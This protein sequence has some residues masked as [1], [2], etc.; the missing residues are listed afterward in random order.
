[1]LVVGHRGASA[2]ERENSVAAFERA[3]AQG[4]DGAELDVRRTAD[5]TLAVHHDETLADGRRLLELGR[6]ELDGHVA[7]LPAVLDACRPLG[8]VNVEIK[9]WPEDGDYE[10]EESLV[11]AVAELLEARDELDD[12]RILVSG[13][14]LGTIDRMQ[15]LAPSI[16]TGWLLG[17]FDDPAPLIDKAASRGHV[18]VHPH[19]LFVDERFI[20][21]AHAAELKVNT[22]TCD[23]PD[24][25]RWLAEIGTDAVIT[26]APDVAL[27]ALGR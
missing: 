25:I 18:A 2:V 13:F 14:H 8:L 5:G 23:D 26:N 19:H 9:N 3:V 12:G 4:A 20:E 16:A 21:L 1:M 7:D 10:P 6:E 22:W 24:R 27:R 11:D 17:V 15:V